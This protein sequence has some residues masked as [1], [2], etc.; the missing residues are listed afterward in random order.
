[1]LKEL[2][3]VQVEC[4]RINLTAININCITDVRADY[5]SLR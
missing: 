4:N 5:I 2:L 3:Q 1:M